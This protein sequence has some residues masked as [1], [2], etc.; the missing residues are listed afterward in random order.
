MRFTAGGHTVVRSS[1]AWRAR[2]A[3]ALCTSLLLA[4][5]TFASAAVSSQPGGVILDGYGGLHVFGGASVNT[6]SAPYW[7]G[8]DIA[9]AAAVRSDGSGGWT[10]DGWG[11]IH[12]WGTAPAITTPGYWTGWDIARDM[13]MTSR[14]SDGVIDG[15]QG[16]V[17]DGFGG[18][19]P[20]GG[21]PTLT[22]PYPGTD[23]ARS[24]MV[25]LSAGESA[26]PDGGWILFADGSVHAFGAAVGQPA[27]VSLSGRPLWV[28]LRGAPGAGYV[29]GHWGV[30]QAWGGVSPYW[31]GYGDW[32]TWDIERDIA[33]LRTDAP[34]A[35]QP[36]S[37]SAA[38][39]FAAAGKP[40]GGV[41]LDAWGGLHGFGETQLNTSSAPYWPGWDIARAVQ[42]REDGSG[43]W[44]LDGWGA[45]HRWGTNPGLTVPISWL[46]VDI[47]RAFVAS[48]VDANGV[49]DGVSGYV[50][51]GFGGIHPW[52][53]APVI[54]GPEY[55]LGF[56]IYRGLAIHRN[57]Q[58]AP[59]GGWAIDDV[60][61][62]HAFGAA[63]AIGDA[64][65]DPGRPLYTGLHQSAFGWYSV[66][67]GG[68]V[69]P[70]GGGY[71]QPSWRGWSDF[72]SW[73]I[74]RDVALINPAYPLASS[75]PLSPDA[76]QHFNAAVAGRYLL[77][78]PMARQLHSLDCE[79]ATMQMVLAARGTQVN[80]DWL[81]HFWG[82][83]LRAAVRDSAGNIL[84]WGDPYTA[85]VGNVNG[86]EWNASGY[87]VYYPPLVKV[88]Q[89]LG[90][91]VIG[92]EQ[93][94]VSQLFDLVVSGYPAAVEGSFNLAWATPR[95]YTAWD[96][97]P[98]QYVLNNHV[99]A[100]VGVDFGARTVI[101]NDPYSG[102]RK[103]FSWAD[104]T[105]SFTYIDNMAT[106][107]S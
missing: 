70:F 86:S 14:G 82:A 94:T 24:L 43:G 75:Q 3:A 107:V 99:F 35:A 81:L 22:G 17:L 38:A 89:Y 9:R 50:L 83:D 100:L 13:V 85:F 97:R 93:W 7:T 102:T 52:G 96:G 21:A 59:D 28:K 56:D 5:A 76:A 44:T 46:G 6:N 91:S 73:D 36:V 84:Q 30:V 57:A 69:L 77:D 23:V 18:V 53:Q 105:R 78:V 58:G 80:Q 19:H 11:G 49:A 31:S 104:F 88:S 63:P 98:V 33:L 45:V 61:R 20:W 103:T 2:W 62:T 54:G 90:H 16:Y 55:L 101:I 51:D 8:W 10:L 64:T 1:S 72:G 34:A 39:V 32:G 48:S 40:S 12:A 67:R 4:P 71:L 95:T 74:V 41:T 66:T 25:H 92:K 26:T 29:V 15:R 68:V 79:A 47:A 27:P 65:P 37:S 106:V 42:V 60:G 87:G